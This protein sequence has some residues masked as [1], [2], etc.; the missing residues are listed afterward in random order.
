M[1]TFS[2]VARIYEGIFIIWYVLDF[3]ATIIKYI[4]TWTFMIQ[5]MVAYILACG[6]NS[7]EAKEIK[8]GKTYFKR[9]ERTKEELEEEVDTLGA[10]NARLEREEGMW[11]AFAVMLLSNEVVPVTLS[12]DIIKEAFEHGSH[13][14]RNM[15]MLIKTQW[16]N[17]DI[18]VEDMIDA[19]RGE[20][21]SKG[22]DTG[23]TAEEKQKCI[24]AYKTWKAQNK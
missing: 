15:Y 4:A 24:Q 20:L 23:A 6:V 11:K 9:V 10:E 2:I 1:R 5:Y 3:Y 18:N 8:M 21:E 22:Y 7:G 19:L 13:V 14:Y 16:K 17:E 12:P